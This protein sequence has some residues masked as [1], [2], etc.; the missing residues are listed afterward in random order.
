MIRT[1][2]FSF[3]RGKMLAVSVAGDLP[4]TF[5][6]TYTLE[7]TLEDWCDSSGYGFIKILDYYPG[8]NISELGSG[9]FS[10]R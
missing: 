3:H 10:Y 9:T 5:P 1:K 7:E 6:L 2:N 8:R 4:E